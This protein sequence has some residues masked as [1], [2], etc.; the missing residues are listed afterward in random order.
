M[1]SGR[2]LIE[3]QKERL[4]RLAA[5]LAQ[6][7]ARLASLNRETKILAAPP[8]PHHHA[9]KLR[10]YVTGL[11]DECDTLSKRLELSNGMSYLD[12]YLIFTSSKF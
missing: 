5:A 12:I 3:R 8:P 10:A 1:I 6:E 9:Q 4:G 2:S 11:R 7:K